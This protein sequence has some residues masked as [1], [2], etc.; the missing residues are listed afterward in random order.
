MDK[1]L[2]VFGGEAIFLEGKVVAQT[3]SGN[4]GYSVDKSLVLGYLPV[5]L[6]TQSRFE[7]EA[8]GER[9]FASLVKGAAYD[10]G[11]KKILC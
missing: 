7:V 8:F 10:P 4:F 2:P 5:E 1:P 11:R 3:T 9:S 6:L